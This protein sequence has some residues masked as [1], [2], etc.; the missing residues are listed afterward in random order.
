MKE[1]N[2]HVNRN[3]S[4]LGKREM[5]A[6]VRRLFRRAAIGIFAIGFVTAAVFVGERASAQVS[7]TETAAVK[8]DF[9]QAANNDSGACGV[10][11]GEACSLG[12]VHWIGSIVQ[13][14]NATYFEGM[15][16]PQRVVFDEI[17]PTATAG[18]V[19]TLSFSHQAT[20]GGVHAYDFLTSWQQAVLAADFIAPTSPGLLT[21][22]NGSP[23]RPFYDGADDACGEDLGPPSSLE[24]TCNSLHKGANCVDVPAPDDPFLSVDGSTQSR[25]NAYE[26]AFPFGPGNRSI[27]ICGNT[28]ISATSLTLCGHTVADFMDTGDSDIKYMLKWTSTSTQILVEFA[29]HLSVSGDP[30]GGA[31]RWGIGKGAAGISGGPYHF[32]LD[33]LG[34]TATAA[35]ACV[36]FDVT[37][38]GSQDNQIK[39]ADIIV[40]QGCCLLNGDCV[41]TSTT[42]CTGLGGTV[43]AEGT[44]CTPVEACCLPNNLCLDLLPECCTRKGGVS[45]G[46]G[47]SCDP[48]PCGGACCNYDTGT[49]QSNVTAD[50]CVKTDQ[51]QFFPGDKCVVDGGTVI[52]PEHR[53]ACC[54]YETGTCISDV[55]VSQCAAIQP[56][57]IQRDWFKRELCFADGGTISCPEH[58]G[59][60]C[61]KR[62]ADLALRCRDGIAESACPLDDPSQVSWWKGLTCAVL[63]PG[64]T[65][66]TGACCDR[67]QPGGVCVSG[68]PASQCNTANP[69]I[70]WYKGEDCVENGGTIDCTEHTGACC[71]KRIADPALRCRDGIA[72][73]ACVIDDPSQVS[74]WKGL[75]CAELDPA[76]CTEHTGACCD[77]AQLGG[78]CVGPVAESVCISGLGFEQPEFFKDETCTTVEQAG[79]CLEHTGACC[80][81]AAPG[82]SCTTRT[83][84]AC[85]ALPSPAQ[86]EFFKGLS[87]TDV[88]VKL[89]CEEHTGACCD[90]S[91]PGGVCNN[92]IPESQCNPTGNPQITWY[93][94]TACAD[95]TPGCT[96]HTGACCDKRIA[97]PALRCRDNIAESLCPIDEPTQKSWYKNT[98]CANLSPPCLEH[99]GACCDRR[100]ADP[101]LRCLNDIPESQCVID[102]S[103]QK[104][105]WKGQTCAD[106]GAGCTEHTGACCERDA[107]GG[108]CVNDVP[109]SVCLATREQPIF[110]KGLSCSDPSAPCPEHT[111]ACCNGYTGI[112]QNFVPESQCPTEDPQYRWEKFTLCDD[113]VPVCEEHKGAC[114]DKRIADLALRCRN[115]IPESQCPIV[116][117]TQQSWH[118]STLC[119]NLS[120]P[121]TEHTGA[122]CDRRI[123]EPALRCRD[124]IPASLC[125]IV[126]SRQQSWSKGETCAGLDPPCTEHTGACC[127]KRIVDPA[128]RCRDAVAESLCV[129]DDPDQV[130]WTKGTLCQELEPACTEHTGA[131]CDR[132]IPDVAL[133]CRDGIAKSACTIDDPTQVTWTKD[134][135]CAELG[136]PCAEHTGACC[137]MSLPGGG[138][139]SRVL[140]RDCDV[141]NPQIRWYKDVLCIQDGGT[142]D[143]LEHTGA[144]CDQRIADPAVRCR[145]D[146][147]E[148]LCP[149]D[150]PRQVQWYKDTPCSAVVCPEHT[151]ACCDGDVFGTCQND[152]PASQCGCKKC[153]FY[154]DTPCI[155]IECTHNVIPTVSQWG[156]AVLTLLLLTGAK[157]YFGRRPAKAA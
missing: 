43:N 7:P 15:S 110:Y 21:G 78:F 107:P 18:N 85:L 95:L 53:G 17:A 33:K 39:G 2:D 101:A 5:K 83:E 135:L 104:S 1:N 87:C 51:R 86:P 89:R 98:L 118:K 91:Q 156:L 57:P 88:E 6:P 109:E 140:P 74:W 154:K 145:N 105:W 79:L 37:S 112:C 11:P 99:T 155:E 133:R 42:N 48:N 141:S 3:G 58:T 50:Q 49:C 67:S 132:R 103:T 8:V 77:H 151:G 130:S 117:S 82:G 120:P 47:S 94:F 139:R 114:C 76:V 34:S 10:S 122:C 111:G 80:D 44:I 153:S 32:N 14:T 113:L 12:D 19:H 129:I 123:A 45:K 65:E 146:I 108:S 72:Q 31:L 136:L 41:I 127:D 38:L 60:C 70:S 102:D 29:G 35:P 148:S 131:C 90:A 149:I 13:I 68:V 62:I 73:S 126:D 116:D 52:C 81:H 138:C 46:P 92:D 30:S 128:L 61:D 69:Q 124:N 22:N 63:D 134:T 100:I 144:C 36:Q 152:V 56:D 9:K 54:D 28:A 147:P 59:A 66:H 16:N 150:D 64:C 137:D 115:D 75:T 55:L 125:P 71:D 96:E 142:L 27:R 20:K 143:C 93:K 23:D 4:P 121:C 119:A 106:L 24:A 84:S 40:Q 26:S 97:N 157:I 25:I